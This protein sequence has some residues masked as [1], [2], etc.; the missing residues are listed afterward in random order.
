[1]QQNT[2]IKLRVQKGDSATMTHMK[3]QSNYE[4]QTPTIKQRK[5]FAQIGMQNAYTEISAHTRFKYAQFV[6][7]CILK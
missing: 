7:K 5:T 3:T 2:K 1:M 6:K 4:T